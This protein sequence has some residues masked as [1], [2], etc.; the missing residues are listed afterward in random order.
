MI[1]HGMYIFPILETY[2]PFFSTLY[3]TKSM[4]YEIFSK[5]RKNLETTRT[6]DFFVKIHANLVYNSYF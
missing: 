5:K 1:L 2:Y 6:F 3:Y 4:S